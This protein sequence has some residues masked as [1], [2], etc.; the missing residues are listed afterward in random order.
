M[1]IEFSEEYTLSNFGVLEFL[2]ISLF[3][4]KGMTSLPIKC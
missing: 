3:Y 4:N 2:Q 1:F